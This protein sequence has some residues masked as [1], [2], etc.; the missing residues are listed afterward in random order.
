MTPAFRFLYMSHI[1]PYPIWGGEK[2]RAAGLIQLLSNLGSVQA[3][4]GNETSEQLP[5]TE[6]GPNV[7]FHPFDFLT[8]MKPVVRYYLENPA[9]VRHI[10]QILDKSPIDVAIIDY[11]FYGK[12]I[13][14]FQK[15]GIPVIYGT[16]NA[17]AQLTKQEVLHYAGKKALEKWVLYQLQHLHERIYFPQANGFMVVSEQDQDYYAQWIDPQ[18]MIQIPN[19]IYSALYPDFTKEKNSTN[20]RKIAMTANFTVFQNQ[21]GLEW[22]LRKIWHPF[23]LFEQ[24]ELLLIG[25]GSK[26][27]L[28]QMNPMSSI[29]NVAATGEVDSISDALRDANVAVV[30]LRYGSGTRLKILEAMWHQIPLVATSLGV[31]GIQGE[32]EKHFLIADDPETF[33]QHL[34]RL[35]SIEVRNSI[36][37]HATALLHQQYTLDVHQE[38]FLHF[39]KQT[40]LPAGKL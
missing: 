23:R 5:G 13:R 33:A 6:T 18:R 25:R 4:V 12:Y 34:M 38:R 3:I 35:Q 8:H 24:F 27:I 40:I 39:V 37:E 30:P 1:S 15:R 31:E 9:L 7:Q 11:Q 21:D 26:E 17:E 32:A 16:H 19:F 2:I 10:E 20:A 14:F 29:P 22:F 36:V 28:D